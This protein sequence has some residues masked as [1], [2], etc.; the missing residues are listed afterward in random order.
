MIGTPF[1]ITPFGVGVVEVSHGWLETA[2]FYVRFEDGARRWLRAEECELNA[3]RPDWYREPATD[4]I[5]GYV[6]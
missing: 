3:E 4:L 2:A 1:V 5:A 6:S